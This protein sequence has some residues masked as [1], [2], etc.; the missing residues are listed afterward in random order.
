MG[1]YERKKW[2]A[3][4]HYVP[5]DGQKIAYVNRIYLDKTDQ[6]HI[7]HHKILYMNQNWIVLKWG[8]TDHPP[9]VVDR[10]TNFYW[11]I[12]DAI[13]NSRNNRSWDRIPTTAVGYFYEESK[14][15]TR[16]MKEH[17]REV[18][19]RRMIASHEVNLVDNMNRIYSIFQE[20]SST[21]ELDENGNLIIPDYPTLI[22]FSRLAGCKP[23]FP[24]MVDAMEK[25]GEL[26]KRLKDRYYN[27]DE[28]IITS[29]STDDRNN[30]SAN[31]NNRFVPGMISTHAEMLKEYVDKQ[32]QDVLD[33]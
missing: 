19:R 25:I 16:M 12:P 15:E 11:S 14:D 28:T 7:T 3:V 2:Y 26:G 6:Y 33:S 17:L 23:Q 5:D 32:I 29:Q 24:D 20:V 13:K 31:L 30:D 27:D 8:G 9:L 4:D 10:A 22:D 1:H 18:N 21:W